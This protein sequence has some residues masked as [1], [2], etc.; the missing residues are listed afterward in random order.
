MDR[1][2]AIYYEIASAFRNLDKAESKKYALR[3][4]ELNPKSGKPYLLLAEMYSSGT[5]E[6]GANDFERKALV[7]LAMDAAKKAENAEPKYKATVAKTAPLLALKKYL[8]PFRA[9]SKRRR[10]QWE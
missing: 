2:A 6:C 10:K 9:F 5:K 3:S 8:W 7:W 1:K 4:A